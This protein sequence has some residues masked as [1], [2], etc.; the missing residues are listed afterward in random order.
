MICARAALR[1]GGLTVSRVR[2]VDT[3]GAVGFQCLRSRDYPQKAGVRPVAERRLRTRR[4]L[5]L[6]KHLSRSRPRAAAAGLPSSARYLR[7]WHG[8]GGRTSG[9]G[10]AR[11]FTVCRPLSGSYGHA[12]E[13]NVARH[14]P[15]DLRG[16]AFLRARARGPGGGPTPFAEPLGSCNSPWAD[17][18]RGSARTALAHLKMRAPT[19]NDF[20]GACGSSPVGAS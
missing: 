12:H 7:H 18:H 11:A 13:Q 14:R 3:I 5:L 17:A 2:P 15:L 9:A 1:A 16:L 20:W 19:V 4:R 10:G 6:R 8:A